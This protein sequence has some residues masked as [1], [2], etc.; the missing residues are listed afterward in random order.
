MVHLFRLIL[1]MW[2]GA[3]SI[4]A[5]RADILVEFDSG[6]PMT[7]ERNDLG[8]TSTPRVTATFRFAGDT[9]PERFTRGQKSSGLLLGYTISDGTHSITRIRSTETMTLAVDY[10]PA[11]S[12]RSGRVIGSVGLLVIPPGSGLDGLQIGMGQNGS[13]LVQ[14]WIDSE[15]RTAARKFRATSKGGRWSFRH[16]PAL[17]SPLRQCPMFDALEQ[18]AD[19]LYKLANA[20]TR[21]DKVFDLAVADILTQGYNSGYARLGLSIPESAFAEALGT[22]ASR[23]GLRLEIATTIKSKADWSRILARFGRTGDRGGETNEP[24]GIPVTLGALDISN[25]SIEFFCTLDP[26]LMGHA[27]GDLYKSGYID[28]QLYGEIAPKIL[29]Y[30][31]LKLV[32]D[33]GFFALTESV[34]GAWFAEA[35]A[36]TVALNRAQALALRA[37]SERKLLYAPIETFGLPVAVETAEAVN[38]SF[39]AQFVRQGHKAEDWIPSWKAST[40]VSTVAGYRSFRA[41]RVYVEG[42]S[43]EVSQWMTTENLRGLSALEIKELLSLK[44]VPTHVIEIEV[45]QGA[46]YL[47]GLTHGG[48][49]QLFVNDISKLRP[50]ADTRR[51]LP[52]P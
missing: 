44:S 10:Y 28:A 25:N 14:A 1:W 11:T 19:E 39:L 32:R 23:N 52:L 16:V 51:A 46:E 27:W 24:R 3:A 21:D 20:I 45:S 29:L 17:H 49:R 4:S 48:G 50:L 2:L 37:A 7:V 12:R 36:G 40:F 33:V 8:F 34:V 41:Y 15:T 18:R 43:R 9:L 42:S 5:A 38:A 6:G 35:G 22:T 30:D 47:I 13:A 31:F 26:E